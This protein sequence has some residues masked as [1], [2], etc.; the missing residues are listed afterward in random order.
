[1]PRECSC[2]LGETPYCEGDA[3]ACKCE[4]D[5]CARIDCGGGTGGQCGA[6]GCAC[7]CDEATCAESCGGPSQ[8]EDEGF[9]T[10]CPLPN[11][12]A[13]ADSCNAECDEYCGECSENC[14]GSNCYCGDT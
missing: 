9:C 4:E 12:F 1:M 6:D 14:F 5:T 11:T 8:C 10:C 7:I 3:C 2:P 13:S